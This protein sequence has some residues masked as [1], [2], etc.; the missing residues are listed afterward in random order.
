MIRDV[1]SYFIH[2]VTLNTMKKIKNEEYVFYNDNIYDRK[3]NE[4]Y[5]LKKNVED[6]SL[7]NYECLVNKRNYSMSQVICLS[8]TAE[9]FDDKI[10]QYI[11]NRIINS[12]HVN[13]FDGKAKFIIR[14]LFKAYYENPKQMNKSQLEYLSNLIN[15]NLDNYYELEFIKDNKKI[16]DI[17]FDSK[18]PEFILDLKNVSKLIKLLKLEIK[19]E[20]LNGPGIKLNLNFIKE[21]N[22]RMCKISAKWGHVDREGIKLI[23]FD[24]ILRKINLMNKSEIMEEKDE[25]KK[26]KILFIKCLL[27]NHYAYLS[28]ICDY[29]AGMTDNYAKK[30]YEK[31]YLV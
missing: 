14:Q 7:L 2:D 26:K 28:V 18:N 5:F 30:E 16:R 22:G 4:E 20:Y 12:Y 10:H 1:I 3:E 6:N 19:L 15:N 9:E 13:R 27:E 21:I 17:K 29:I 31:L 23:I 8:E 24:E 25:I 11:E